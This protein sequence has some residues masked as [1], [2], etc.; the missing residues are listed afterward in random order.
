MKNRWKQRGFALMTAL[1]L[2]LSAAGFAEAPGDMIDAPVCSE[3]VEQVEVLDETE[4]CDLLN[5]DEADVAPVDPEVTLTPA[6]MV[7]P[8]PG[9]MDTP[10]GEPEPDEADIPEGEPEP[11]EADI[12]EGE[13]APEATDIPEGEPEPDEADIPAGEPESDEADIPEGEP[14]PAATD[15]PEGEPEPD[16]ADIPEGEP[17]PEATDI[18]AG[19]PA[20]ATT[21]APEKAAA[22]QVSDRAEEAIV[23][24]KAALEAPKS[25][26]FPKAKL[27][28]GKGERT[29]LIASPP[30]DTAPVQ[31]SYTSSKP[32]VVSVDG[33]GNLHARK[34]GTAKITA[35][36]SNGLKA[37]CKVVVRKAPSKVKVSEKK[38]ILCLEEQRALKAKLPRGSASAITWSSA[39][40]AVATVDAAGNVRGVASGTVRITA[41]TFNGRQARCT[42]TV[43]GGRKPTTLSLPSRTMTLGLKQKVQLT[44]QLG[45]G[46]AARFTYS[47]SKKRVVS[48]SRGGLL[49]AKK[50]GT[51]KITV[52]THNG[53]KFK[54]TVKVVKAPA[55]VTLSAGKLSLAVGKSAALKAKLPKGTYSPITW[56][57]SDAGVASVDAD[58]NVQALKA[59]K[60]QITATTFNG[61]SA[62]CTV[63]VTEPA[64]TQENPGSVA[65]NLTN[66]QMV[67]NLRASSALGGKKNAICS[68]AEMMLNAGYEPAFVA[69]LCANVYSEGSYGFFESSKYI[70]NYLKR[71][72]YF[73]YLDGGDY[74]KKDSSGKYVLTTVYL[75]P[76]EIATYTGTVEAKPRFGAANYY[77]D[78]W[79]GKK[80]WNCDLN[81]LQKFMDVLTEGKWQGKF[82]LGV[83]QWTGGRTRKLMKLYRK[84]AGENSATITEAQV[85]AAE[86]EMI[87]YDLNGDYKKVYTGWRSENKSALHCPEAANSAGSWICLKY[88]IPANKEES[89]VK[90]GK[91]AAKFYKIM[92]GIS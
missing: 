27:Y 41:R 34:K 86:N 36:S 51:A 28:M 4:F 17:V 11:D 70:A 80:V 56:R 60:A 16:E 43:L 59:G 50:K 30:A 57:S 1:A 65:P 12:P 26:A 77:R 45:A 76:E 58:G 75:A 92:V 85:I 38:L 83:T 78:N 25:L 3:D 8:V 40:P 35:T 89:A 10:E 61:K 88:E 67:A 14:A 68:V 55:K 49:T 84:H 2:I 18:P 81:E 15:I 52:K 53:L 72:K 46:E 31:V 13:P 64:A 66:A 47:S 39:N 24:P 9:D 42:V 29:Q 23:A 21:D 22:P 7:D 82:G 79:S 74:Y 91:N 37:T 62:A 44:P 5:G 6:P 19:E 71:P 48:V 33:A 90:R 20:P 32:S 54:L 69:G 73:C 87:L 63:T